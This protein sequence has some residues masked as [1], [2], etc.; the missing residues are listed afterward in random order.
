MQAHQEHDCDSGLDAKDVVSGSRYFGV[1]PHIASGIDDVGK[2]KLIGHNLA[3]A[4]KGAAIDKGAVCDIGD[5]AILIQPVHRP[6]IEP[7]IHI[8][9][10]GFLGG[11][12][13]DIGVFDAFI[14]LGVGAVFVVLV[15]IHL[16]GIIGWI[17]DDHGDFA[18][19]LAFDAFGIF[20]GDAK[21]V[22]FGIFLHIHIVIQGI[23]KAEVFKFRIALHLLFVGKFDVEVGDVVGQDFHFIGMEFVAIFI[24]QLVRRDVIDD[25]ADEG[26]G[27]GGGIQ[28]FHAT[29]FQHLAKVFVQQVVCAVDHEAHDLIGG[30]DHA[31]A[32]SFFGIVAFVKCF[33]DHL[34]ELLF[35][36]MIG[37][38]RGA[39]IDRVIIVLDA[40]QA[41]I[42]Q[43]FAKECIHQLFQ[44]VGDVIFLM[45]VGLIKD[46]IEDIRGENVLDHHFA[47][48][49]FGD[50][51]IHHFAQE[52][53][54]EITVVA[55]VR[56]ALR[57]L[58]D[59]LTQG[60]GDDRHI[61]FK[62]LDGLAKFPHF[63]AFEAHK[64]F[65]QLVKGGHIL[66]AG[67]HHP[68]SVLDQYGAGAVLKED[69]V[70]R[71]AFFQLF[72]DLSVQIIH[73]VL[74]FPIA[75]IQDQIVLQRAVRDHVASLFATDGNLCHQAQVFAF[76][77]FI[78]EFDGGLADGRFIAARAQPLQS[79][80]FVQ[81]IADRKIAH[82]SLRKEFF[83]Y[84]LAGLWWS[85]VFSGER[86]FQVAGCRLQ[87]S[88][89]PRVEQGRRC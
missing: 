56:V 50:G 17:A 8:I 2:V 40:G 78:N 77:I 32:V 33:I 15:F 41:L 52:F 20:V 4:I 80:Q 14:D 10:L 65:Q 86:C 42:A 39:G 47:D 36:V 3:E 59:E 45:E 75:P 5:Y 22:H 30:I 13:F 19:V 44:L 29:V 89:R 28:D 85:S 63:R 35:L 46:G 38:L 74:A 82:V 68:I 76:G 57:F 37:D 26:S 7:R 9:D 23:H 12:V 27:A 64:G 34:E 83:S 58:D 73:L 31:Q 60:L 70:I 69:V 61:T 87:D 66:K 72:V 25:I 67:I 43:V 62:E 84:N 71:I 53:Q 55:I 24:F 16:V 18:F 81:I 88:T 49:F 54:K 6:A 21:D 51:G 11:A 79:I 48:V 1:L